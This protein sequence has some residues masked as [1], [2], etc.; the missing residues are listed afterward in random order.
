MT[1]GGAQRPVA[2]ALDPM[3]R[4]GVEALLEAD[5]R[6]NLFL[7]ATLRDQGLRA[8]AGGG[9]WGVL[10]GEEPRCLAWQGPQP[11][12]P[13]EPEGLVV[14]CGEPAHGRLLGARLA[15]LSPPRMLIGPREVGDALWEGL[16]APR[17]RTWF[18]QRL[19]VAE[20]P[21]AGP[22]LPL[23][24]AR[25]ED[26]PRLAEQSARMMAEDLGEDPR[27]LDAA[28]HRR[29]VRARIEAGLILVGE[30]EGEPVFKLDLGSR[31]GGGVQVGGTWVEPAFRGRGLAAA[32][33]RGALELLRRR[34]AFVTLHLNEANRPAWAAYLRAGFR[35]S[36]PYRLAVRAGPEARAGGNAGP[37][38]A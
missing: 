10:V 38:G 22:R 14:P 34:C 24:R 36:T 13:E 15:E 28:G 4:L 2:R 23:R 29:R 17:A 26:L 11:A 30:V 19:M 5:P 9:F 18:D 12:S 27:L 20:E 25:A 1:G 37:A 6:S 3:D 31:A 16:G 33:M 7:A 35:P 32:G 21:S 8:G